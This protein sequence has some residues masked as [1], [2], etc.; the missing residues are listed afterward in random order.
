MTGKLLESDS[1]CGSAWTWGSE[2]CT[3]FKYAA[4]IWGRFSGTKIISFSG[5]ITAF[6]TPESMTSFGLFWTPTS[7]ASTRLFWASVV[8]YWV[9]GW[10]LIW[11]NLICLKNKI[12]WQNKEINASENFRF[13]AKIELKESSKSFL[14]STIRDICRIEFKMS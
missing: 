4:S 13:K 2:A 9:Y 7:R 10:I 6:W 8:T 12:N 5:L 11:L 14:R 1:C 3:W